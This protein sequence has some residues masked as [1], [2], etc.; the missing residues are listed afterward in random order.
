MKKAKSS[1]S[2]LCRPGTIKGTMPE[3]GGMF[4]P[5]RFVDR[6][7]QLDKECHDVFDKAT[8]G[9]SESDFISGHKRMAGME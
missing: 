7:A 8:G 2:E 6:T 4:R 5:Q 3:L 9:K 1:H